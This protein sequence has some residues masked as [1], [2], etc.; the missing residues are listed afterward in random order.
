ME[1]YLIPMFA[2]HILYETNTDGNCTNMMVKV[3]FCIVNSF[4]IKYWISHCSQ[5]FPCS[6]TAQSVGAIIVI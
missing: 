4:I 1:Y 3:R 6:G 2:G 5:F